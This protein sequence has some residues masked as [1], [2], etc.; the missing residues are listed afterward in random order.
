MVVGLPDVD[1]APGPVLKWVGGK[2]QLLPELLGR[3]P[4]R[5]GRYHEPFLGGGA[6]AFTV[7]PRAASLADANSELINFYRQVR[8]NVDE[9]IVLAKRH[10]YDRDHYYEVRS[11]DRVPGLS[12]LTELQRAARFLYLNRTC[13]NGLYRVNGSGH[14]NVP[15]GSYRNPTI[16]NES[17]LRALSSYLRGPGVQLALSE[18]EESLKHPERG[19]FVYLDPPYDPLSPTA[20]FTDYS[21]G[22]FDRGAQVALRDACVELDRR[23]VKFMLSNS[24]TDFILEIYSGLKV[25]QIGARR[26]VSARGSGRVPVDEVIVRNY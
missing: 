14:F 9:L 21:R 15:F 23:G 10:R 20:S 11:W 16:V 13:F 2:R 4:K 26:S 18:F 7:A 1:A 24:S 17:R 12:N 22:G 8:D 25:E 19:D 6:I 3:F 5:F